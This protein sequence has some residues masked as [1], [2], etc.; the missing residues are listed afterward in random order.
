MKKTII[1][2]L[3]IFAAIA[4]FSSCMSHNRLPKVNSVLLSFASI[5][6]PEEGGANFLEITTDGDDVVSP[7]YN[8]TDKKIQTS[9]PATDGISWYPYSVIAVSPDGQKIGYINRK[10]ETCNVMI[11]NATSG[12][13]SIQR[14]FRTD[15][16]DFSFSPDGSKLCYTEYRDKTQGIFMMNSDQGTTVQRI[17]P[18][19]T[20][21]QGP[22]ITKAG[23]VIYFSRW[24]GN[25]NYSLWSYDP[26]KG[27][28]SNYS[29]GLTPCVDPTNDKII[30]CAR[31]TYDDAINTVKIRTRIIRGVK[32]IYY[33][34]E[35]TP[36]MEIWK[37]N[38]ETGTEEVVLSDK[39]K[40][41]S[42]PQVSPD[43]QWLLFV[44]GNSANN[45]IWNTDLYV[46]RTDGTH[47]TQLTFHPG[48]DLSGVWAPDGKSIYFVSQRG[49]KT[50]AYNVWKMDFNL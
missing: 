44:G 34:N 40:S 14:T 47:F 36:R 43:G 50:G 19:N 37:L 4:L 6:V 8:M 48:N 5:S 38:T 15:V 45:K 11:K 20:D 46:M 42:T 33:F 24:E 23:N 10:N 41:Y 39:G 22:T 7:G 17:S 30:Y 49:S 12:G 1:L 13:S 29:R 25:K 21:D 28:F 31:Y 27:L 2:S 18:T 35:T 16:R 26:N 32:T 9:T 3:I